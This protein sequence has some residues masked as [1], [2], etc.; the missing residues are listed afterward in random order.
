MG[1]SNLIG[2]AVRLSGT[3][4]RF[5]RA[6]PLLGEDTDDILREL[7]YDEETLARLRERGVTGARP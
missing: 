2:N 3:P 6:A 7:G 5:H 4:A 1:P